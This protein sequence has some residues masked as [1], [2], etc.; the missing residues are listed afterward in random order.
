MKKLEE[1]M[2][3]EEK[4]KSIID[5]YFKK[6]MGDKALRNGYNALIRSRVCIKHYH[7]KLKCK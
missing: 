5:G 1:V 2:A 3:L 7:K 4:A 6:E